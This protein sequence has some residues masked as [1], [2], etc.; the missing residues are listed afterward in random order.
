MEKGDLVKV[1]YDMWLVETNEL[2]ET[3]NAELAKEK[4]IESKNATYGPVPILIGKERIPKGLD[5][6][7]QKAE[8]GKEYT[9][10]IPPKDAFGERDPKKIEVH[11]RSEILRLP[12]FRGRDAEEPMV[13]MEINFRNRTA[14]IAGMTAGRVRLDF[15]PKYAG[16][17]IRYKYIIREKAETT[18]QKV[19]WLLR[20][21]YAPVEFKVET[22]DSEAT[23]VLPDRAK[24]DP[25]WMTAKLPIVNDLRETIG[26]KTVR[27]IEEYIKKEEKTE[28]KKTESEPAK[29]NNEPKKE[30]EEKKE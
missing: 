23:I 9:V 13:G 2:V 19:E 22:T 11:S 7:L 1:D 21:H 3:T 20:M 18:K 6:S 10:E 12:Q 29:E 16:R 8:I 28:E 24:F 25:R 4:K 26:L 5:E 27:F 14:I 17:T 30:P 15:N